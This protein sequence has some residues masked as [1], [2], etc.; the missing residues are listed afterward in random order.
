MRSRRENEQELKTALVGRSRPIQDLRNLI[1]RV[2]AL[3][4]PI[5]LAGEAGTGKEL[6][7]RL[8]HRFSQRATGPIV[9]VNLA[10]VSPQLA[11]AQLFGHTKGAFTGAFRDQRGLVESANGGTLLLDEVDQASLEVQALLL[12]LLENRSFRRLGSDAIR[13]VDVRVIATT[14]DDF[15]SL[16]REG[17]I[18]QDLLHRLAGMVLRIPP[19]RE[20]AEDI[21]ELTDL[22]LKRIHGTQGIKVALSKPAMSVLKAYPY[23]GNIRELQNILQRA[24]I[25][26]DGKTISPRHLA[27]TTDTRKQA[28]PSVHSLRSELESVKRELDDLRR[29]AVSA[30]PIWEGRSFPTESDF[31]FVLMPFSDDADIQK[32]F[33]NHVK[34]VLEQKC[35]LRCGRADDIYD[36]SGV[37]QSV[38]E[39][40]NRARLIVADLTGRN[41]NVFYELGIAHTL[42]KPVI[43]LTQSMDF[44]PFD[45]RHLRCVV[46]EYKPTS[47]TRL[48]GALER[49]VK[50]VLSATRGATK[51]VLKQE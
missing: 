9:A 12:S 14:R 44:V 18:R 42:G 33:Q 48:E 8:I 6:V 15:A 32:V 7:A 49:T 40:I 13:T 1:L 39:G 41:P 46:Y 25:L 38:W 20:R 2:S 21:P 36:I 23:P 50:T 31:C 5:L 34:P 30:D 22:L 37:M 19:L 4:I 28:E 24:A 16:A 29:N 43:M 10:A 51:Q 35:G 27:L 17:R 11:A 47:I 45:L 3:D 26:S